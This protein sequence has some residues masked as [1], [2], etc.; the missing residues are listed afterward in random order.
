[1]YGVEIDIYGKKDV[2][3][4]GEAADGATSVNLNVATSIKVIADSN[5]DFSLEI[6]TEGIPE[7]EFVITVGGLEKTVYLGV[8]EPTPTPSPSPTPTPTPIID[9]GS[10]TYPSISGTHCGAIIPNK[11]ITV[12]RV[13]TYPC[14]GTGGHSEYVRIENNSGWNVTARWGGYSEDWHNITFKESFKLQPGVQYNYTIITGSYPQIIHQHEA[15]VT[16]GTIRCTKFIDANEKT[17]Y[18]WIPAIILR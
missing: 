15:N 4:Y 3:V 7:G 16:S 10:G 2:K 14:S 13:Y 17:Y 6:D 5:G 1:L 9:T 8:P 11:T 18:D 12:H